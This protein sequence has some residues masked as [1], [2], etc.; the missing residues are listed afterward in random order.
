MPQSLEKKFLSKINVDNAMKNLFYLIPTL[1][2]FV[3]C[4]RDPFA[5]WA[6]FPKQQF[7]SY[8]PYEIGQT[9]NFVNSAAV[10]TVTL[11]VAENRFI[12]NMCKSPELNCYGFEDAILNCRL[13][14]ES[15]ALD[16]TIGTSGKRSDLNA[17][18]EY[19][20]THYK[21]EAIVSNHTEFATLLTDTLCLTG[22]NGHI[23]VVQGQG[24]VEFSSGNAVWKLKQ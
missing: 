15:N 7:C 16:F 4:S 5:G 8:L 6:E 23:I 20:S 9:V 22:E 13:E 18:C 19:G 14:N 12:Y 24:I 1:L 17:V 11:N 3:G 10:D 21:Y 2:L